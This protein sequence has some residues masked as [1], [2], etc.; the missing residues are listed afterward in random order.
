MTGGCVYIQGVGV[1]LRKKRCYLRGLWGTGYGAGLQTV[2][3]GCHPGG[4]AEIDKFMG[5][6]NINSRTMCP[7]RRISMK[8]RDLFVCGVLLTI[9]FTVSI[10][11]L[12]PEGQWLFLGFLVAS[13]FVLG[14]LLQ[15][16]LIEDALD[17]DNYEPSEE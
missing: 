12:L 13:S 14:M 10:T 2:F 5:Y 11:A 16:A 17:P 3:G 15:S 4:V 8:I 9:I 1:K 7:H 6:D